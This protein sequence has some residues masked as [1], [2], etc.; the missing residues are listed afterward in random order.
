[1][2][3][4][5]ICTYIN[6]IYCFKAIQLQGFEADRHLLRCLLSY[7]DLRDSEGPRN[8]SHKDY[9]Q[10]Q[11]LARQCTILLNKP[12]LTSILCFA[13]DNPL[14]SN[15][16]Y[17][18]KLLFYFVFNLFILFYFSPKNHQYNSLFSSVEYYI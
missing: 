6:V 14:H 10:V 13:L 18:F 12:A 7:I 16:V 15:K 1:M 11:L 17:L 4:L 8:T 5:P 2:F 9:Y 3:L